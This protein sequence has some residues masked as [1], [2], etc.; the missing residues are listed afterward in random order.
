MKLHTASTLVCSGYQRLSLDCAWQK[1]WLTFQ[2]KYWC[3]PVPQTYCTKSPGVAPPRKNRGVR[4]L[5][6]HLA[7]TCG[8]LL[9]RFFFT[10]SGLGGSTF[11]VLPGRL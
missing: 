5:H 4:F 11:L 2:S 1:N 6:D 10:V 8:L 9:R 7:T 3:A